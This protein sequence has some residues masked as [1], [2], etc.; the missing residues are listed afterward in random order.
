[1]SWDSLLL[2]FDQFIIVIYGKGI[3]PWWKWNFLLFSVDISFPSSLEDFCTFC[4]QMFQ[5]CLLFF[6][7][8]FLMNAMYF[9]WRK[10]FINQNLDEEHIHCSWGIIVY[11]ISPWTSIYLSVCPS[12]DS[13]CV[14][15][16][17]CEYMCISIHAY[18]FSYLLISFF[19]KYT[20][21]LIQSV[22]L[23]SFC[24][25]EKSTYLQ[26][27]SIGFYIVKLFERNTKER[28]R[29]T[30]KKAEKWRKKY[31]HSDSPLSL[32][33]TCQPEADPEHVNV[34][35]PFK[36]SP[37]QRTMLWKIRQKSRS[38]GRKEEV[39]IHGDFIKQG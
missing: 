12:I 13:F 8:I 26:H 4:N 6:R 32:V 20:F 11:I 18:L 27:G 2:Y 14:Y 17:I 30:G 22:T 9:C 36:S 35:T 16:H 10:V 25:S 19:K 5:A 1:M 38:S 37:A 15:I 34:S 21:I 7:F 39:S 33:L 31:T 28:G 3:C 29:K 24:K 23:C